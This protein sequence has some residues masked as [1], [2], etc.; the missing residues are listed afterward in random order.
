MFHSLM[1]EFTVTN[2]HYQPYLQASIHFIIKIS[3]TKPDT[4]DAG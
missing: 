3:E 1:E 4:R 2:E